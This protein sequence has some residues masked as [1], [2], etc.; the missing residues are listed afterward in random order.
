MDTGTARR[1]AARSE[2]SVEDLAV[3]HVRPVEM[4]LVTGI[5]GFDEEVVHHVMS[6][7]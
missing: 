1:K 6:S 5:P 4:T 3:A 2:S 7:M